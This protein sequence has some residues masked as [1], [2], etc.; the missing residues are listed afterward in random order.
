LAKSF[1]RRDLVDEIY[2]IDIAYDPAFRKAAK[3]QGYDAIYTAD[4]ALGGDFGISHDSMVPLDFNDVDAIGGNL[5]ELL[6]RFGN[7]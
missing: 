1:K 7:E 5:A 4:D 3:K 2:P 6:K